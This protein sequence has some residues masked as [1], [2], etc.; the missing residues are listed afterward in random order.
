MFINAITGHENP[1]LST[2]VYQQS[3]RISS[4]QE[5]QEQQAE[6]RYYMR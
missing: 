1:T 5:E 6:W 2:N 4:Q 3:S